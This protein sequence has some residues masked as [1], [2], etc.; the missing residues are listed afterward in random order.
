MW[1]IEP[2]S[3]MEKKELEELD[4]NW[5]NLSFMS[6]KFNDYELFNV[7]HKWWDKIDSREIFNKDD[8]YKHI[9]LIN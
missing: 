7:E 8:I 9:L 3:S 1:V 5:V 4:F 2:K 6:K